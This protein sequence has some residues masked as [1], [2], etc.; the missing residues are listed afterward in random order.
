MGKP[1]FESN[2]FD[3][4][5]HSL[6]YPCKH[7]FTQYL[8]LPHCPSTCHALCYGNGDSC[9]HRDVPCVSR[10]LGRTWISTVTLM[11]YEGE[12]WGLGEH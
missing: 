10:P 6:I 7:R 8:F 3:W 12:G 2:L 11:H 9:E 4:L 5:G 1:E